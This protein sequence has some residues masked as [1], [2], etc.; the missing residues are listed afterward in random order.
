MKENTSL[1]D[2]S[3]MTKQPFYKKIDADLELKLVDELD[4]P[5]LFQLIET[6]R[7]YLSQWLPWIEATQRVDD[8][9]AFIRSAQIQFQTNETISC[10]IW[11]QGQIVGTIGYHPFNWVKR[12]V[13]IGYWLAAQ[14]QGHGI[15]TRA[16]QALITY[17]FD[18]LQLNKVEIRCGVDNIRSCAIPQRL[19]FR[20]EGIIHEGEWH[21]DHY[22]DLRLYGLL[23]SEWKYKVTP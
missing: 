2:F 19:G 3:V 23:A 22:I 5:T 10:S 21:H 14:F 15:V 1:E 7:T 20:Q 6:N 13:E 4:A 11:Y 17:A 12:S 8:E 16:C 18:E 9:L